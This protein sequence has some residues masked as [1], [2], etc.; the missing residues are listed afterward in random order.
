MQRVPEERL[1]KAVFYL[2]L[3]EGTRP[4]ER[5]KKRWKDHLKE[6]QGK[7]YLPWRV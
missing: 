3:A 2:E 4:I 7:L 1:P 5:R 6:I